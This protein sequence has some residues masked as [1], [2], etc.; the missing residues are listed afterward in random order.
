MNGAVFYDPQRRRWKRLRRGV[1]VLGLALTVL[2]VFFIVMV[3]RNTRLPQVLLPQQVHSYHAIKEAEKRHP[4]P[5]L[6]RRKSQKPA[7][8]VRLN[9][10]EGIRGA[11][12]V[13][14]DPAS[15]S[16]LREYLRQ[17]DMLFPEWLHVLTADGR[18]QA[19]NED[20]SRFDV[21]KNGAVGRVDD[22]VMPL[23][24]SE[25]AQTEVLP[26]INN[27]DGTRWVD[28]SKLLSDPDARLWLRQQLLL[29]LASD[30]YGGLTLDF[31]AFPEAAQPGYRA[32]L[33]ELEEGLHAR[34][35][36]LYVAVPA[37]N[38]DFDYADVAAH[39][40]GVILM[41][42]DE[43]YPGG[44][45]GAVAS[46]MVHQESPIRAEAHSGGQIA[47]CHRQLRLRLAA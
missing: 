39:S 24:R 25:Q 1:D 13:N 26:L 45:P 33:G 32:L 43:H 21:I 40:D 8:Q 38:L 6:A 28:I 7:T 9:S 4:K 5:P 44:A 15:Y 27:F 3:L 35:L 47:V 10:D 29:F 12:Y 19:L 46:Q 14:W 2:V 22:K 23:L 31:E 18:V 30:H 37:Q 17:I 34:G 20:G 41:N 16:S 11:F 42:Y 36:K